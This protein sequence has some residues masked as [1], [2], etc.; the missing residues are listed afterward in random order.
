MRWRDCTG[1][2]VVVLVAVFS[3]LKAVSGDRFIVKP[4][5]SGEWRVD[6]NYYKEETDEREVHSYIFRP[7]IELGYMTAKSL[8]ALDYTADFYFYDDKDD[9]DKV[10]S[11]EDTDGF[12]GHTLS[13]ESRT[14][15]FKP[16][17][18]KFKITNI[19]WYLYFFIT[20]NQNFIITIV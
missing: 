1:L 14:R 16:C 17:I 7:G 9:G 18:N 2:L 12:V 5:V 3:P 6:S 20:N 10:S 13:F 8:V 19:A 15:P 4:K 11:D